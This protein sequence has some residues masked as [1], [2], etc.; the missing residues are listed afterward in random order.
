MKGTI[1]GKTYL[2][3]PEQLLGLGWIGIFTSAIAFTSWAVALAK[4][5]TAKIS[6]LAYITPFLSLIWTAIIL[7]ETISV[8][9]V[10][11]LALIILGILIQNKTKKATPT[12]QKHHGLPE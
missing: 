9:S 10:I 2:P 6:N 5:N 12:E 1:T 8:F 4:G 3:A 7:K 11:G